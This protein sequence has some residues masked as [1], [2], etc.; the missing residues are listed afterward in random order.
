MTAADAYA[1]C[2]RVMEGEGTRIIPLSPCDTIERDFCERE[3][4]S[5]HKARLFQCKIPLGVYGTQSYYASTILIYHYSP[6]AADVGA[7]GR[8]SHSTW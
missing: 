1:L 6:H 5:L 7:D 3:L 4:F 2:I 8:D